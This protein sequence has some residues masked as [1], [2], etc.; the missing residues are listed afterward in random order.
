MHQ[1]DAST[2]KK[3]GITSLLLME[4][5]AERITEHIADIVADIQQ[6][7]FV[8]F[9]GGG[10][11]GGDGFAI[12]R[13]L[14]GR[15]ANVDCYAIKSFKHYS[16]DNLSNYNRIKPI[17]ILHDINSDSDIPAIQGSDIVV[18][19]ILG[20]GLSRPISGFVADIVR[21]I[22]ISSAFTISIDIPSGL[23][24]Y[25]IASM[26]DVS[27]VY[28]DCTLT[29]GTPFVSLMLPENQDC[30]G[31]FRI[32]DIGLSGMEGDDFITPYFYVTDSEVAEYY[33]PRK[34]FSHKGTFGHTLL[35]SGSKGKAGAAI[36]C[37][38]ACH[39][40]GAG[41]VSAH[42]PSALLDIM[43]TA[44]PETMVDVDSN[45][46]IV[47]LV[48]GLDKYKA[49]AAGPGL[50]TDSITAAMLES[51]LGAVERN[52]VLDADAL[53]IMAANP[54]MLDM[55]PRDAI[56]TPHPKE[57]E[58][59]FGNTAN[60]LER[61]ELARKMA[62]RYNIIIV[63]K[64]AHTAVCCSDGSVYFNSTGNP[65]MATAGSGDVLTGIIAALLSQ[66]YRPRL[67]AIMGVWLH[68]KAADIV[69][70]P[71]GLLASD[72]IGNLPAAFKIIAG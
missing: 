32:V 50:G 41:L 47:S 13:M 69:D 24:D 55:V 67:A 56:L 63:L 70:V 54:A 36:L 3:E 46:S 18:D 66:G 29:I 44:S 28:A 6:K 23:S 11:N 43:Q 17:G 65:S 19:A 53:N 33:I 68:G 15:G 12:A 22:N 9:C 40:A 1:L 72:I 45:C 10:N 52:L 48:D 27:E 35:V 31:D 4:R 25:G 20:S 26:N 38:R 42:V 39:R 34:K 8:I 64:G 21:A 51:L 57:F 5:A 7:H 16:D 30:V 58:R 14:H 60:S 37:A 49:V 71:Q 62:A 61:I 59:L 2:I